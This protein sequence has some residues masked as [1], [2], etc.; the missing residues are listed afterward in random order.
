MVDVLVQCCL[1]ENVRLSGFGLPKHHLRVVAVHER[2]PVHLYRAE[3]KR[4]VKITIM[5]CISLLLKTFY[6]E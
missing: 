6:S 3:K 4:F 2:F 5:D 1:V